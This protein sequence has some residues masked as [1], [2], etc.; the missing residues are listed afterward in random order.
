[1]ASESIKLEINNWNEFQPRKDLKS[2]SWIRIQSDVFFSENF[3]YLDNNQKLLFFYVLTYA[4]KKN[5]NQISLNLDFTIE[6]LKQKKQE[7][8]SG[9]EK[10][11]SLGILTVV[12]SDSSRTNTDLCTTIRNDTI[13]NDTIRYVTT[14]AFDFE[15]AYNLYPLKKG[16][17]PGLKKLSRDI[18][19]EAD[20][21]NLQKAVFNYSEEIRLNNTP[22]QFI[23]H[24]STFANQWLDWVD[25]IPSAK[26]HSAQPL[27][28]HFTAQAKRLG[29]T[30]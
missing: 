5:S 19:T 1:M 8:I 29:V 24:F 14:Q 13:R 12:V 23:K 26:N 25:F 17:T 3:F 18:K 11:E 7:I 20:F 6:K 22:P 4:G 30:K 15:S 9:I 16:K 2:L 21:E 28:D 10:L 27:T